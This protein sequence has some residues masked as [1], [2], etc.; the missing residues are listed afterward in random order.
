M[1]KQGTKPDPVPP[2]PSFEGVKVRSPKSNRRSSTLV[3]R[4]V[5]PLRV[6]LVMVGA[7]NTGKSCLIKRYCE[8]RF[9]SKYMP[10]VG[11]DYGATRIFVDKREV[12]VHIFDT[13]GLQMFIDVRSEFYRDAHGILLVFDVTNR[14]SFDSL[15]DWV[16]E[17]RAETGDTRTLD[18]I[19]CFLCANKC[20]VEKDR[21]EVDEVEARL[22]AELYG[23]SYFETSASSG[24]GI[25]DMFQ[26]FFSQLVRVVDAGTVK[27]PSA[28][29][30]MAGTVT[31]VKEKMTTNI[32]NKQQLNTQQPSPEQASLIRRLKTGRDPWEQL[33]V[34][35]GAHKDEV[36]KIYRKHA[37]LLH[38]DKT[39]VSPAQE[40]F[41]LLGQAR[42]AILRTCRD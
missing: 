12:S 3:N 13:S 15:G 28:N 5:K 30:R 6:R 41:K 33:G 2:G 39:E 42:S 24:E 35:R 11:I 10:T 25:G 1:S 36:N 34:K 21:R 7:A 20:E 26:A 31:K 22:W 23:F 37:V 4:T 38:P 9:V 18:N 14:D 29:K 16:R 19:V 40:A 17:M 27:T 8:K 32:S